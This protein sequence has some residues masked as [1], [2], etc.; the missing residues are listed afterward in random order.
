MMPSSE[1]KPSHYHTPEQLALLHE[2]MQTPLD[3]G[4][5]FH[6]PTNCKGCHGFDTLGIANIDLNGVDVNLYDDWETSM[7]GL[8][9][10]DP[11]WRA[12]VS[13]EIQV[14]PG[15]AN[16]LQTFCTSCHA[17]M[18]HYTAQYKHQQFY[19]LADLENDSLGRAGVACSSCHAIGT[20]GLGN[21]FSGQIPYDTNR[22]IY[23]PFDN[24][25]QGP[26]QLYVGLTPVK[27]DHVSESRMC[28]PCHTLIS[29]V[30]DLSGVPTGASFVE[31][32]TYHEWVN[33]AYPAQLTVCQSCHMPQIED[34]IKI[35]NG[36]T[37][38]PGRSPF[39]LH[40]FAGANSFM[41]NLIKNNKTAL[42]VNA[43]D[44]N[45][46]STLSAINTMLTK[47]SVL[48]ETT[49]GAIAN[50][51]AF[52]NVSLTNKAGH[53]FP[54]G[55]PS[56]RAVLQFIVTKANGDTLFASGLFDANKE[57][58][59]IDPVYE[60]HYD[61]ITDQSQVQIYEMVMGDVNGD[62]TT[63]LE[64]SAI[65]LK[66]NRIPPLGFTTQH[67]NYDTC[68]IAGSALTD[69][70]F[71]KTGLVEG[72]GKDI[73]HY[74]VALNGYSGLMN[75]SAAMYYQAVPPAW[76]TEMFTFTSPQIDT[77]QQMFNAA[78]QTP[79]VMLTD[80]L[81]NVST[82]VKNISEQS[83]LT[84]TPNPTSSGK[85]FIAGVDLLVV[86]EVKVYNAAGELVTE[87]T[88][89]AQ[90]KS[91]QID[92][93]KQTGIYFIRVKTLKGNFTE[94]ILRL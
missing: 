43:E 11:L 10:V 1:V 44:A 83:L 79:V 37:A 77:F 32:A 35:A 54:S 55:Y 4:E 8:S 28:S 62:K 81:L 48:I 15:H 34:P 84:F 89:P 41:V 59:N 40:Q 56:R 66:D 86:E 13:H 39:N 70:D 45:F 9:G 46:D 21:L 69:P 25:M 85:V 6:T 65:K 58:I 68:Y 7:M 22:F 19:T 51:T 27:S 93:P 17:P 64:R 90:K 5:Y 57:V 12:K 26:M 52:F 20:D 47:N 31:Q 75:I 67:N 29:G 2:R 18:G 92:L 38:L 53:K 94:K 24:P 42:G 91:L 49:T 33:S 63:V 23:G 16:E 14:N 36:Y 88:N 87:L 60:T 73:V 61:Q 71:N 82:D 72:S 3:S 50:D 78:D 80:T 76:L 30:V 74:H